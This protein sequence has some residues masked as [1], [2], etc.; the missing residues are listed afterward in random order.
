VVGTGDVLQILVWKE[1]ELTR[2]VSVR[3]DG[4]ITLPL[5]GD[6]VA[7]GRTPADLGAELTRHLT[8]FLEAPVVTVAVAQ[9]NSTRFFVLGQ[10]KTPGAYPLSGRTTVIQALA[11]AG[12]FTE[13]AKTDRILIIRDDPGMRVPLTVNFKKLEGDNDLGQNVLLRPG[14]TIVV[15]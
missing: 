5:L 2:E 11:L 10:V 9:A 6:V 3:L 4:R 14:D 8:R 15:P 1:P 12:G 7:A 13:F